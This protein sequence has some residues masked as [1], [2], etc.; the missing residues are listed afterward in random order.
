M[1]QTEAGK[2]AGLCKE[3]CFFVIRQR[4]CATVA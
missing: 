1:F 3:L 2:M 4:S